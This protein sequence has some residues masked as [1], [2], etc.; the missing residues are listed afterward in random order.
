MKGIPKGISLNTI[1]K[2]P[3]TFYPILKTGRK[4]SIAFLMGLRHLISIKKTSM[5]SCPSWVPTQAI[6]H[7][8]R[9]DHYLV[10]LDQDSLLFTINLG[11]I[12]LNP[13]NS[14]IGHLEYPDYLVIDLDPENITFDAVVEVAQAFHELFE[15]YEIPSYCKTSGATGL[16][17]YIPTGAAYTYEQVRRL[18]ELFARLVH[19]QLPN[20]TS[21]VRTPSKRQGRVYLDYLQNN[22]GQTVAAPYCVRPRPKAPVSTPLEWKEVKPGL[23]PTFFTI[24]NTGPRLKK[25]GDLFAPILKKG[26][27]LAA[28]LKKFE[29]LT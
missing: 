18:A 24:E 27:D 14:R 4:L 11:C 13:F 23:D 25:K 22:F 20:T 7:Q 29:K 2:L 8:N 6:E 9:E 21:M 17:V 12:D 10:I 5:T 28:V 15:Q 26:I 3:P 19:Q 1:I 16:H